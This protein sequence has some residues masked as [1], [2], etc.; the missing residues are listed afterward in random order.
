M[1]LMRHSLYVVDCLNGYVY[2]SN[3]ISMSF[4]NQKLFVEKIGASMHFP[5]L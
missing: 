3:L 1:L 5:S 4:R 2:N